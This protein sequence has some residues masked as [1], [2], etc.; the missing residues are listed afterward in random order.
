MTEPNPEQVVRRFYAA[1]AARERDTVERMLSDDFVFTS[2][3]DDHIDKS[4]WFERCWPNSERIRGFDI[5]TLIERDGTVC[6]R[7]L[8]ERRG[9][10]S[11]FRNT[12]LLRVDG[13]G[14]IVEA[15]VY[16]GRDVPAILLAG[17]AQEQSAPLK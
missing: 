4:A 15:D 16:F 17:T 6:V 12:E 14:R 1:F 11:K 2:P 9:D 5:E 13:T 8:A 7:Y 10:G 3:R